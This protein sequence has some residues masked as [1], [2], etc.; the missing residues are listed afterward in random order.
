[1][2]KKRRIRGVFV[3]IFHRLSG[4][5]LII[6]LGLQLATG[7]AQASPSPEQWVQTVAALHRHGVLLGLTVFLLVF[8]GLYGVRTI[9]LDLGVRRERLLFWCCNASGL[10]L[11]GLFVGLCLRVLK[12]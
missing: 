10:V 11:F 8:H 4:V 6:L 9:L 1:V 5:L 7:L 2:N 3:W 12:P